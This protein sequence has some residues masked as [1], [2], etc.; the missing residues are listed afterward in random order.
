MSNRIPINNFGTPIYSTMEGGLSKIAAD[1]TYLNVNGNDQ[2]ASD[3]DMANF[4]ISNVKMP[5][6]N[7]DSANKFYVDNHVIS[8][9]T[10][11]QQSIDC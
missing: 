2:M 11:I 8:L 7:L 6:Q 4:K 1:R 3:L 5:E 9:Q 10:Q